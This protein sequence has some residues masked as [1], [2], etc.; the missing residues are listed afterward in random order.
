MRAT[1]RNVENLR[2]DDDEFFGG[3]E[4]PDPVYEDNDSGNDSDIEN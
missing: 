3:Y 2:N 4:P 1:I